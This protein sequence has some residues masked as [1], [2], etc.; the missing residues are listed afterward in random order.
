[1]KLKFPSV[2]I[3]L[4]IITIC[5]VGYLLTRTIT[6]KELE[7]TSITFVSKQV[8]ID[9]PVSVSFFS[10]GS[11]PIILPATKAEIE[12][13]FLLHMILETEGKYVT[14]TKVKAI[15]IVKP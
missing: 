15:Q 10:D 6:T 13:D 7:V 12:S 9:E 14:L 11:K 3:A 1:M 5:Y 8:C 2:I 4:Q